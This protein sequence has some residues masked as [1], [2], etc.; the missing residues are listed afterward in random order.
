MTS[1]TIKIT[2]A[3]IIQLNNVLQLHRNILFSHQSA[4]SM[5]EKKD[6]REGGAGGKK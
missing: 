4:A 3:V 1:S 5:T 6:I 2:F